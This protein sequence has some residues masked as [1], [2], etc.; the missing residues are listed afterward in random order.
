MN[1]PMRSLPA[2]PLLLALVLL[3]GGCMGYRLMR[4]EEIEIP[5]YSPRPVAVPAACDTLINRVAERAAAGGMSEGEGRIVSFCQ[6]QQ[7]IRA[8][9][10]EAADRKIEAHARAA[11]FALHLATVVIG[12]TI[13]VLAWVF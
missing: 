1:G 12:T 6:Q 10:E 7:L 13:A 9:E 11:D 3:S 2:L 5:D 8:Q 4:P